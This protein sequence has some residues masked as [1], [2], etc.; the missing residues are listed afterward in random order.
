MAIIIRADSDEVSIT[1]VAS[2]IKN[3]GVVAYPTET[4]YGLGADPV[5]EKAVEK[6]Y[7]IK[8][9]GF[10]KPIPII[11]GSPDDLPRFVVD[12]SPLAS[13]LMA[14]FWPG[15]LTL[16]FNASKSIPERLTGGTGKVGIRLSSHPTA[17]LLAQKMLGA[18]TTTSANRSGGPE[19]TSAGQ[20]LS[21]LG[22]SID[23]V[24]D[25][26]KTVGGMGSTIVDATLDPPVVIR[27]GVIPSSL[28]FGAIKLSAET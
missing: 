24:I 27:E 15:G 13:I 28:I 3:G 14:Q 8:G 25:G 1:S 9:R 26:G 4:F 7:A 23:A 19:C 11:I 22:D 12:T 2:I 16:L 18:I 20:V 10:D 5:N 17:T 21:A 6:I